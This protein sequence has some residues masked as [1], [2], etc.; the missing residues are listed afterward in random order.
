MSLFCV[1]SKTTRVRSP[2]RVAGISA[3][4]EN[5]YFLSKAQHSLQVQAPGI[6]VSPD[7]NDRKGA[8]LFIFKQRVGGSLTVEA[9]LAISVFLFAVLGM[10][11][12]FFVIRTE[13]QIQGALE[14]TGNQLACIPETASLPAAALIFQ[15]KLAEDGVDTSSVVGGQLGIS[16]GRSTIMGHEPI[17]DLVAVYQM[18][19]P[20]FP[21]GISISI[22]QRSRKRAFG[23]AAYLSSTETT[24]VYVTRQGEVY[25]EDLYC[26]YIRPK[27]EAVAIS[28]VS[29]RRNGSGSIYYA[30]ELCCDEAADVDVWI[31]RWGEAYHLS[32]HCRGIW[33]DVERISIEEAWGMRGCSKCSANIGEEE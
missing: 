15:G 17:V 22:V 1:D 29:E 23:E 24:Y 19:L 26:T 10:L 3:E 12:F 5:N 13:I 27:T 20:F 18:K 7:H 9:A 30:C 32:E 6:A 25:H 21:E 31:T 2:R 33:H 4:T 14:Q 16:L 8:S 28:E 11:G